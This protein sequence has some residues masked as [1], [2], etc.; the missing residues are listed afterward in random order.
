M[1]RKIR[2]TFEYLAL[3]G[4]VDPAMIRQ[5]AQDATAIGDILAG[6]MDA[7]LDLGS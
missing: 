3:D 6:F 4:A 2:F 1:V 7:G 5:D